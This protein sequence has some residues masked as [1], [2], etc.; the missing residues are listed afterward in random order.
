MRRWTSLCASAEI[1]SASVEPGRHALTLRDQRGVQTLRYGPLLAYDA[2][3]R[4]LE[5]WMEVQDGSLRLRVNTAGARYPIIV[6][7]W[8]QAAKLTYA[9]GAAGDLLGRSV[10]VDE[11]GDTVVVGAP[12]TTIA[13]IATRAQ[14]MCS[15]SPTGGWATASTYRRTDRL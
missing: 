1:L 12:G 11:T 3:G 6:D 14:S 10:A 13:G 4:E 15:S 8:V 5:S 2:S 7:P 9:S